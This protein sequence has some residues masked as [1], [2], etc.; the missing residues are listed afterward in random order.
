MKTT[1]RTQE[2][3]EIVFRSHAPLVGRAFVG[4][5]LGF[6]AAFFL[7]HLVNG[8]VEYRVATLHEWW[9]A[10]PGFLV[11]L[12]LS[13]S[14][15][16]PAWCLVMLRRSVVLDVAG[17][18]VLQVTDFLVYRKVRT[19]QVSQVSTFQVRDAREPSSRR[20]VLSP[21]YAAE[22][23]LTT[24]E[25]ILVGIEDTVGDA[26]RVTMAVARCLGKPEGT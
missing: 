23:V 2:T 15:G 13:V 6:P 22:L 4:A 17:G 24:G 7:Y 25:R 19:Y 16:V 8:L 14:F 3:G 5:A 10:L 9:A 21:F 26:N 12:A 18:R 11:V 1:W 20:R